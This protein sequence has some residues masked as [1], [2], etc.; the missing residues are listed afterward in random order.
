MYVCIY[1]IYI[2][3]YIWI[4]NEDEY[5]LADKLAVQRRVIEIKFC[6]LRRK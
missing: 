1:I 5:V 3:M 2:Y 6:F 4:D